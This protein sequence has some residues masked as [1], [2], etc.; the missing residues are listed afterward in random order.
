[1]G[2]LDHASWRARGLARKHTSI[3]EGGVKID[4]F[5]TGLEGWEMKPKPDGQGADVRG[6][7]REPREPRLAPQELRTRGQG[8]SQCTEC[9]RRN[10]DEWLKA[11]RLY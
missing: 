3:L 1:M 9:D 7:K 11:T 4:E 2:P 5:S 10:E 8:A 6:E